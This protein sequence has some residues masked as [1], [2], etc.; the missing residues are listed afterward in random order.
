MFIIQSVIYK[1]LTSLVV[2]SASQPSCSFLSI[3]TFP[4]RL[5]FPSSCLTRSFASRT[6]AYGTSDTRLFENQRYNLPLYKVSS[7]SLYFQTIAVF[8]YLLQR[9]ILCN[10]Y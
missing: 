9:M 4:K 3:E 1:R 8:Q 10:K 7:N 2:P 6:F 5:Y